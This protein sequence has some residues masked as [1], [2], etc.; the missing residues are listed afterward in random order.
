MRPT[1]FNDL[2][3][4]DRLSWFQV[5][6]DKLILDPDVGPVI[7]VHTHLSLAFVLPSLVR[8]RRVTE[9]VKTYLPE[10]ARAIDL[11][12]YSNSNL[13]PGDLSRMKRDL[14]L[15]NFH[16]F[17]MRQTH[18]AA[19]LLR[20]MSDM[21][22]THAAILAVDLPVISSNAERYIAIGREEPR[23]IPFGSVHPLS[24]MSRR[25]VKKLA[26]LGARGLKVHPA[27]QYF[28]P[29]DPKAMAVYGACE[30]AGLPVFWHC[31]PVGIELERS[32]HMSQV[33]FYEEPIAAFPEVTFFLG[34][35][36]ALQYEEAIVLARRYPNT[37]MDLSSQGL[38]AVRAIIESVDHDRIVYGS[39]WPFYHQA[40]GIARV[41]LATEG[42][43]ALR[44]KLLHDNAARFLWL[45]TR[46][47]RRAP[48]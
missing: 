25:R 23:L 27:S 11:E 40:L 30:E 8:Q 38:T 12:P 45:R 44:R 26:R 6:D 39:D 33:R 20:R 22:I 43:G 17:G 36:G 35:S 32:R 28:Y 29:N 2:L 18:T 16:P 37:V 46:L 24:P 19:N 5:A 48:A 34:H 13:T 31:G 15:G 4:L 47:S 14:T 9:E 41:L 7:D 10:R 1:Q 42:D 3:D 21:Q